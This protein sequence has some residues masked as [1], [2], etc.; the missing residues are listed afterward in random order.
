MMGSPGRTPMSPSEADPVIGPGTPR[1]DSWSLRTLVE[2]VSGRSIEEFQE[3]GREPHPY[4]RVKPPPA[5]AT[6]PDAAAPPTPAEPALDPVDRYSPP[7]AGETGRRSHAPG[8]HHHAPSLAREPPLRESPLRRPE[9]VYLHYLL[10]H[11][12]R[13]SDNALR[14]LD[15]AV[16]E[17]L[18]HRAVGPAPP[19]TAEPPETAP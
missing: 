5:G 13:L 9:R 7:L 8:A 2:D 10:L 18:R 12:D 3:P 6:P 17:E 15:Q 1:R 14:Y 4:L 16:D 11:L 19:V